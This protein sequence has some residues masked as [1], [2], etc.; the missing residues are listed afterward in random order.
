MLQQLI[1]SL[2]S[3]IDNFMV[4]G[5]GDAKMAAVNV[6]NQ[7]NFVYFVV[8]W[9]LCG[10][11]GIYLAQFK[12]AGDPEG[13][14]QAFRFK[15]LSAL[16][17][18]GLYLILCWTLP[19]QL[20]AAMTMGNSAQAEIVEIGAGY[21]RLSSF[22]FF[23]I[24][25][26]TAIGTA[27]REIGKARV[28]LVISVVATLINTLG[29]WLLI[30]GNWGAPRWEVTGAAIATIG[31]R[32][33][34]AAVFLIY[35]RRKK[36]DFFVPLG[37]LLAVDKQLMVEIIGKSGM[38]LLS[39]T[40]W[41]VSETVVTAIYN[42]RGG[43]E[44]VAGM[45]AGFSVANVFFL[46]FGG[47][48]ASAAVVVGGT[49]GAGKLEEAKKRAAWMQSGALIAGIVVGLCALA[50]IL[51]I[52]LVFFNLS[53][54]AKGVTT[55]LVA[56]IA[57]YMPIWTILNAQF[58][59]SRAGG[60]TALGMYVDVSVSLLLFIPGAMLLAALTP[61]GPVTL[62]AIVKSTDGIKYL[63]ARWYL[64]KERWVKNLTA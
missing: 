29:N 52:P 58:A 41:V 48:H 57:F 47:I 4:A 10:A 59:V 44:V 2:V 25:I 23:P 16:L 17:V 51:L 32:A 61:M 33:V 36:V 5:L 12:G 50:S 54:D 11:G 64:K 28:P 55:G 6:A 20:I 9:T 60:D 56:V 37:K 53:P 40:T 26:S 1:M 19:E 42:G 30:Y 46:V 21:L 63:I 45:A 24:A 15:S 31:A 7:I 27:F 35:V 62:F 8:L 18:S 43:A 49:L 39:E 22:T 38:M 3:L 14:R 13:M 34:E